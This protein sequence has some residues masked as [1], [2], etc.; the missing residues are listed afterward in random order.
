MR[1][2]HFDVVML[3]MTVVRTML[4]RKREPVVMVVQWCR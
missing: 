1:K 3:M 4:V 2:I